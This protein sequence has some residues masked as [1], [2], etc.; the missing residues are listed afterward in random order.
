MINSPIEFYDL[1]PWAK[2][3]GF[4]Y[5]FVYHG[6]SMTPIFN[7]GDFLFVRSILRN[8]LMVGDVV[9]FTSSEFTGPVVHRIVALD[10]NNFITQGDHNPLRDVLPIPFEQI[11]GKVELVENKH[12]IYRMTNGVLGL[13]VASVRRSIFYLDHLVRRVFWTPYNLIRKKRLVA[14]FWDPKIIKLQVQSEYGPIIKFIHKE[15]TVAVWDPSCRRFACSKPFD[16]IITHP[17]K[18]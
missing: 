5:C 17:D 16:L 12:G 1:L 11:M 3:R 6:F 13:C 10:N 2:A 18:Q 15:R 9:V 4:T 8:R 14:R 7:N